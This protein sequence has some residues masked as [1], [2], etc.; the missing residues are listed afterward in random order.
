MLLYFLQTY[1][2]YRLILSTDLPLTES[3]LHRVDA[4]S[5]TALVPTFALTMGT[6]SLLELDDRSCLG[7]LAGVTVNLNMMVTWMEVLDW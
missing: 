6:K 3:E 1:I 4:A 7:C 2:V 5:K